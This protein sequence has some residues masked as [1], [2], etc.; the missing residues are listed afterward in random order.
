V[1]DEEPLTCVDLF[2]GAGGL[3]W[4]FTG[5][6][7]ALSRLLRRTSGR[8]LHL[9]ATSLRATVVVAHIRQVTNRDLV[10]VGA[11]RT[12]VLIGG[13]PCRGFS[14]SNVNNRVAV[15]G[16]FPAGTVL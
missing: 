1:P 4:A 9:L 10:G 5:L 7:S 8:Q 2:A 3:A 11:R 13:P 15:S 16:V 6:G 14:H 12:D